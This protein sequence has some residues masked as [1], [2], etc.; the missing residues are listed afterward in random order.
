MAE[1][2]ILPAWAVSYLQENLIDHTHIINALPIDS[3]RFRGGF[4]INSSQGAIFVHKTRLG[5]PKHWFLPLPARHYTFQCDACSE[6]I[7]FV[8]PDVPRTVYCTFCG[9]RYELLLQGGEIVLRRDAGKVQRPTA[10]EAAVAPTPAARRAPSPAPSASAFVHNGYTLYSRPTKTRGGGETMF[11]FFAKKTPTSGTPSAKPA[12]YT[13]GVNS[14]TGLP[15]LRRGD[16]KPEAAGDQCGAITSDGKQCRRTARQGSKYCHIHKKYKPV[17]RDAAYQRQETAPR[18]K[19]AKDT[20]ATTGD[21]GSKAN[22]CAAIRATGGQCTN[23]SRDG[24]K[25]CGTHKG[26]RPAKRLKTTDTKPVGRK[27]KDTKPS[28]R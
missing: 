7:E 5:E 17:T 21:R 4:L 11:Y 20:L 16:K 24:S 15:F 28:L 19:K 27:V 26:Y 22:Q 3:P 6:R 25:Y 8:D 2:D 10:P 13:V 9:A 18:S 14:R 23:R 12:G 1:L